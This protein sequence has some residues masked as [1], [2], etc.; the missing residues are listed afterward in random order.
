M[1]KQLLTHLEQLAKLQLNPSERQRLAA[2]IAQVTA[3]FDELSALDTKD[4]ALHATASESRH[5]LRED[6]VMPSL[7]VA[8]ITSNAATENGCFTAPS[9]VGGEG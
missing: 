7:S 1:D 8:D 6:T 2:D 3:Y 5:L 4:V 9:T